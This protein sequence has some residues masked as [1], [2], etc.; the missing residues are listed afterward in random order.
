MNVS[1]WMDVLYVLVRGYPDGGEE[2]F[3]WDARGNLAT[4][5]DALNRQTHYRYSAAGLPAA[6][7]NAQGET[8]RGHAARCDPLRV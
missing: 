1:L 3:R 8:D 2:Q 5:T 6:R 7:T 4:H